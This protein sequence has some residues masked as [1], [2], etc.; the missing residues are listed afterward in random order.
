MG[1][2]QIDPP[3]F[4]AEPALRAV[5]A[6]LPGARLVG[7]AVRDALA[8]RAVADIDLATPMPPD[9]VVAALGRAG[10][11]HAPTGLQHGTVTA[12]SAGRGFEVTT[13][14]RDEATDGRHATV[15]WTEDW[16]QDAARRDFTFNAMSMRP[17]GCVFDYF[18]GRD[19]LATG[20]VR[21]V[22]EPAA[23]IAEDT[24]RV[25]RYFRF[26]GRYGAAPPD[27]TTAEALRQGARW[28]HRLSAERVWSELKRILGLAAPTDTVRLM[29][30]LGV[31]D[32][33][34][35]GGT[36]LA[37]LERLV[38]AGA[39]AEPL[40]RLAALQPGG[41][42]V[43]RLKLSRSEAATLAGLDGPAPDPSW[44]DDSLRRALAGTPA[45]ALIGRAWLAGGADPAWA[46]L[47]ARLA[48]T[49]RPTFPLAGRDVVRLGVAAGPRVG[50]LLE[51]ARAWWMAGGC[52]ADAAACR[53][54]LARLAAA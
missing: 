52:V 48:S 27:D 33:T 31:L 21:F 5:L 26:H 10:L 32:A 15:V 54:E 23:R 44:D 45:A 37:A 22:G 14:R 51:A 20:R 4:L 38:A 53:A 43:E 34:L 19:D 39:P 47:R 3:A 30:G 28:L 49:P 11:K 9:A 7:G 46:A 6:A 36:D 18:G 40:L 29:A 42:V 16:R 2:F 13:L 41:A 17:D 8:G 1:C 50:V 35:P 25:L 24:L 12:I